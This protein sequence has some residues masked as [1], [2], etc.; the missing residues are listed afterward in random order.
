MLLQPETFDRFYSRFDQPLFLVGGTAVTVASI[1][2]FVFFLS[3][4]FAISFVLQRAIVRLC[5]RR[6]I[7]EGVQYALKRLMHYGIVALGAFLALDNLGISVTAL[8]YRQ[9]MD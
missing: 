1:V 3:L 4:A 8:G 9:G 5:R 2:S 6:G 7:D